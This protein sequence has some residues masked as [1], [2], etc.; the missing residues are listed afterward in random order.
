MVWCGVVWCEASASRATPSEDEGR[1][2][3]KRPKRAFLQT[4]RQNGIAQVSLLACVAGCV[5][6]FEAFKTVTPHLRGGWTRL[7]ALQ[8]K[9]EEERKTTS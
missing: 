9:G 7:Q 4:Q 6:Q 2:C 3:L 5:S 8:G 1:S